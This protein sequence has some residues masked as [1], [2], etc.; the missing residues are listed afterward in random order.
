MHEISPATPCIVLG[1]PRSGTSLLAGWLHHSGV[2]MGDRFLEPDE[3][4]PGGYFEDLDFLELH[5]RFLSRSEA[6]AGRLLEDS[7][8][9]EAPIRC[10]LPEQD[11]QAARALVETRIRAASLWGWKDPRTCYYVDF[12]NELMP[13]AK[14]LL[15][16]RHP[17]EVCASLLRMGRNWDCLFDPLLP[18]RSWTFAMQEALRFVERLPPERISI[19]AAEAMWAKPDKLASE[20][21]QKSKI[22]VDATTLQAIRRVSPSSEAPPVNQRQHAIF[23]KYFPAAAETFESLQ[24]KAPFP[25]TLIKKRWARDPVLKFLESCQVEPSMALFLLYDSIQPSLSETHRE[26]RQV[27]IGHAKDYIRQRF[28]SEEALRQSYDEQSAYLR[29]RLTEMKQLRKDYRELL[30]H[31]N[32][33]KEHIAKLSEFINSVKG[34]QKGG[35]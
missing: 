15:T 31:S 17:L 10:D 7:T 12:W 13:R 21:G 6:E 19:F 9:R 4:N 32:K 23:A 1:A 27:M 5:R 14:Y 33:Q 11:R 2:L 26:A 22:S 20:L 29:E 24:A 34:S 18:L 30:E 28:Q 16:Y 8:L 25:A 3:G 35:K